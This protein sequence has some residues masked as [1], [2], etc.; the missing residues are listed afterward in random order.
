MPAD[1]IMPD[2]YRDLLAAR[3]P[4]TLC[5]VLRLLAPGGPDGFNI[6]SGQ[7]SLL[8]LGMERGFWPAD[9][10]MDEAG[11][12]LMDALLWGVFTTG[13]TC[14]WLPITDDPAGWLV[15]IAGHGWQQLNISTTDFL[16]RWADGRLD[17]PVLPHGAVRRE[18]HLTPAGQP[19]PAPGLPESGRDSLAQLATIV[20][21][22]HPAPVSF[23]WASI[24]ADTGHPLPP[25]Y[26]R[27]HES[28]G[29]AN[30]RADFLAWN[31][32]FTSSPPRL[33]DIHDSYELSPS[34][35]ERHGNRHPWFP[36]P[37]NLLFCGST[38][39]RSLLAWDIR[40]PDPA[41][42][43]VLCISIADAEIFPGTLTELYIAELTGTGPGLA[44][45]GP[46]NP[47]TWAS[48]VWG[49]DATRES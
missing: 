15:L 7:R 35:Q 36:G 23:D 37:D 48:P 30:P 45:I 11:E 42:W 9:A 49:P 20:G 31:G 12:A 17:L 19:A 24:E 38:E 46:G 29:T 33:K 1:V 41:R 10:G 40:N 18:W 8:D 3:G 27:L 39:G 43:P 28:Y 47:A 6:E 5:G 22:G 26:K 14:W 21:P 25:D 16:R 32:I 13:E 44:S 34:E 4:G 2:D